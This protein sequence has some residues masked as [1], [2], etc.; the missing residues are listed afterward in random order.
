MRLTAAF[1]LSLALAAP[2]GAQGAP[3][4]KVADPVYA[5]WARFPV[6]TTVTHTNTTKSPKRRTR[7]DT[8]TQT[9]VELTD[10]KVVVE[11]AAVFEVAGGNIAAPPVRYAFPRFVAAVSGAKPGEVPGAK[12]PAERGER[13]VTVAGKEYKAAYEK[14][15]YKSGELE[16]VQEV[17]T[18]DDVPGLKLM[19]VTVES[20]ANTAKSVREL[21]EI[22][23]PAAKK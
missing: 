9:L 15:K 20:G 23:K 19:E 5:S 4:G 13:T 17:W 22:K 8:A 1:A 3:A 21:V 18:S 11:L 10:E 16:T 14:T 12:R 2:V 6:G 7:S